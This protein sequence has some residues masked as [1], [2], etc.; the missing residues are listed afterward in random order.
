MPG[1]EHVL[2]TVEEE[3]GKIDLNTASPAVLT[4]FFTALTRDQSLGI[5]IAGRIVEDRD[6]RSQGEKA[7]PENGPPLRDHHAARPDRRHLTAAVSE[8]PCAW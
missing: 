3:T 6:S 1:G 4:R 5:R 8:P 7:G 2:V